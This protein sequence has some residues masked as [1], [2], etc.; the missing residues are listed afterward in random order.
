[1]SNAIEEGKRVIDEAIRAGKFP[2]SR[3]GAYERA[4]ARDPR[5]TTKLIASLTPAPELGKAPERTPRGPIAS[6]GGRRIVPAMH[7]GYRFP[8]KLEGAQS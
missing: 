5:G 1:M 4:M 6:D 8:T 2:E 7:G 3:R